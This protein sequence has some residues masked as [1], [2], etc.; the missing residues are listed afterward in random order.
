MSFI[1]LID[2]DKKNIKSIMEN[3]N[4]APTSQDY[5]FGSRIEK[6]FEKPF[7]KFKMNSTSSKIFLISYL[8]EF[9]KH[10]PTLPVLLYQAS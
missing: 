5:R 7:K 2:Y 1:K 3:L 4:L 8:L 10:A 9:N 6:N